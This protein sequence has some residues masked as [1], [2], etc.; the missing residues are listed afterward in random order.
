MGQNNYPFN[1]AF[2]SHFV[3]SPRK[4]TEEVSE[5]ECKGNRLICLVE[6]ISRQDSLQAVTPLPSTVFIPFPVKGGKR[7]KHIVEGN[8]S[9]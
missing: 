7:V 6:G 2:I 8:R 1:I 3:V 9:P 4:I 5:A